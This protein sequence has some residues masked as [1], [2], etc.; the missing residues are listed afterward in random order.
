MCTVPRRSTLPTCETVSLVPRRLLPSPAV[1]GKTAS[2]PT[3]ATNHHRQPLIPIPLSTLST[4]FHAPLPP[5][6]MHPFLAPQSTFSI[7]QHRCPQSAA[8]ASLVHSCHIATHLLP[9]DMPFQDRETTSARDRCH[10]LKLGLRPQPTQSHG[11]P[12]NPSSASLHP[13]PAALVASAPLRQSG[14]CKDASHA[15]SS[16]PY[17]TWA[18]P[19]LSL[20]SEPR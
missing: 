2:H 19:R 20:L 1:T 10:S 8:H 4:L 18:D 7:H 13:S 12:S 5:L 3:S 17:P 9:T 11:G 15:P 16:H 6:A 14:V